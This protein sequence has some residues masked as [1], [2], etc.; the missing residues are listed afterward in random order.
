MNKLRE[1][2]EKR[3]LTPKEAARTLEI[4]MNLYMD[5]ENGLYDDV[6]EVAD[7]M[8]EWE[9]RL[10]KGKVPNV[11]MFSKPIFLSPA[12]GK[13]GTGKTSSV[14]SLAGAL[15]EKFHVLIV[16]CT[17]QVDATLAFLSSEEVSNVETIYDAM[18]RV[19]D[20]RKYIQ[21]TANPMIDIV[22]SDYR[23]DDVEAFLASKINKDQIL[24]ACFNPLVEE[25]MYDFVLMDVSNHL[26]SFADVIWMSA[27]TVYLYMVIRPK[28]FD[29]SQ[30]ART[31]ERIDEK[32][33]Q[34]AIYGNHLVNIG[35]FLNEVNTQ[36]SS[37]DATIDA[38]EM[39]VGDLYI[40]QF[41]H[42]DETINHSQTYRMPV[43]Q[44]KRSSKA[45]K[46]YC[47]LAD[48]I[49]KRIERYENGK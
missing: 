15:S 8:G 13:G 20:I 22:P 36:A 35:V 10:R 16:D 34:M 28:T 31:K 43:T 24:R 5:M 29:L 47:R 19:D 33:R 42:R 6:P 49:V 41:I 21:P 27:E 25:N 40:D 48:E 38:L 14:I 1:I 37:S 39:L 4:R 44:Y 3:G 17:E 11:P 7:K 2:R 23:L 18:N 9:K 26:G 45:A 30:F 46:D 32:S 12:I